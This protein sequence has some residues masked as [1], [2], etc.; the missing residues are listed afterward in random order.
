[1]LSA[2]QGHQGS[3]VHTRAEPTIKCAFSDGFLH[4][5]FQGTA[6][7]ASWRPHFGT[8]SGSH[9]V[10][11]PWHLKLNNY[12]KLNIVQLTLKG[13]NQSPKLSLKLVAACSQ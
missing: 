5:K 6:A 8:G 13:I 2:R 1:M 11:Q 4:G 12:L 3:L 10:R 7:V 9:S